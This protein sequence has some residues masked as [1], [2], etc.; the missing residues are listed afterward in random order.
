MEIRKAG[1]NSDSAVSRQPSTARLR[2]EMSRFIPQLHLPQFLALLPAPHGGRWLSDSGAHGSQPTR[3]PL[4]RCLLPTSKAA[5]CRRAK[6]AKNP[7]GFT[8]QQRFCVGQ[9]RGEEGDCSGVLQ[10]P[11]LGG[12]SKASPPAP[13]PP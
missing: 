2:E 5:R 6:A 12:C 13:A 9:G 10:H 8:P 7:L 1:E 11:V 3:Q 4:S